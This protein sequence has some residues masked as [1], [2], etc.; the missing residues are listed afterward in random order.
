MIS[1]EIF[2]GQREHLSNVLLTF[3]YK[4]FVH[5]LK[6]VNKYVIFLSYSAITKEFLL[7]LFVLKKNVGST[8]KEF[9]HRTKGPS[10]FV[11]LTCILL[12]YR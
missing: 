8:P 3:Q 10:T 2:W 1:F 7:A 9:D 6:H 5:V 12:I 11:T 4:C